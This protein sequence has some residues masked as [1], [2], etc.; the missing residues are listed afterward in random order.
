MLLAYR[1]MIGGGAA[2]F[3][4]GLFHWSVERRISL[5]ALI[6]TSPETLIAFGLVAVLGGFLAHRRVAK[7]RSIAARLVNP[8]PSAQCSHAGNHY[9][10]KPRTRIP[11]LV[12]LCHIP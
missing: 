5:A 12:D 4:V 10:V 2:I 9:P 7:I 8:P 6:I 11:T 1:L 3:G